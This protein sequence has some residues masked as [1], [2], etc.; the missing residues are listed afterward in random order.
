M[1]QIQRHNIDTLY[2]QSPTTKHKHNSNCCHKC[3]THHI[4]NINHI[5][6]YDSLP[7]NN[8]TNISFALYN[9]Q[10]I[11]NNISIEQLTNIAQSQLKYIEYQQY[12]RRLQLPITPPNNRQSYI[13]RHNNVTP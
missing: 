9:K 1:P 7:Y 13:Q 2:N 11:V 3:C 8:D 4:T 6:D 12:L 10:H 5:Y